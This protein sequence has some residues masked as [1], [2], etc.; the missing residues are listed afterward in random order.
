MDSDVTWPAFG[1]VAV[2]GLALY[3]LL[4]P[5]L[6]YTQQR[7]TADPRV[8]MFDLDQQRPPERTAKYLEEAGETLLGL[9]Y[10]PSPCVALADPMPNVRAVL[11]VWIQPDQRDAAMVSAIFGVNPYPGG[12][13]SIHYVEFFT[14]FAS[15]EVAVVQTNN[16]ATLSAFPARPSDL[17]FKFPQVTNVGRLERLH[18][19]LVDRHAPASRK[20]VALVD[21][22]HGDLKAYLRHVLTD[23][24]RHQET[25]GYLRYDDYGCCWRPTLRGAYLMAWGQM[26]PMIA[27]RTQ[28]ML[29]RSRRL[30]AEL[31]R[32]GE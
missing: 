5:W 24:Y 7:M 19:K 15:D 18:Q 6:I 14:R 10:E 20:V 28:R 27:L 16:T 31:E 13:I 4:T 9:G 1:V 30:L 32:G 26:W 25:T 17:T 12:N 29:H 11:Q 23:G 22:F 8:V 21:Q 3:Y 2:T